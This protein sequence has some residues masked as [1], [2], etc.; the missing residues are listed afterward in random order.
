MICN[1]VN[2][3]KFR[4]AEMISHHWTKILNSDLTT[5]EEVTNFLVQ[6]D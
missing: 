1:I 6:G 3:F 2:K 5:E 4:K